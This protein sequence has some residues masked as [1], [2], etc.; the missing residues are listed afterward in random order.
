MHVVTVGHVTNDYLAAA[1]VPGGAALYAGLAA[2]ALG[3]EVTLVTRAGADFVGA[4]LFER[5]HRIHVLPAPRTTT[6]DERYVAERRTVRLLERAG[7]VD[8]PLPPADVVL[9]CPV[10]DEVPDAA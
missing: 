3:A 2:S 1:L 5:F 9:L 10:T 8:M 7:A 4:H 6:F